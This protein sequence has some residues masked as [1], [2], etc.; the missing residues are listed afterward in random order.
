[1]HYARVMPVYQKHSGLA[2]AAAWLAVFALTA[3]YVFA[4][5]HGVVSIDI[6]RD[7]YWGQRIALGEAWPL[8]GPPV[9]TTTLLGPVWYYGVAAA[10]SV[11]GSFTAYFAL[12]G[13]LAASKFALAFVVGRRW[14]GPAFGVS[15][16]VASAAPGIA[17]YQLLGMGHPWFVET[18]LWLAA[19]CALNLRAAPQRQD[20]AFGLGATVALALHA[21]PTAIVL[22]PWAWVVLHRLPATQR[23]RAWVASVVGAAIVFAPVVLAVLFPVLTESSAADHAT[24]ASGVGGF[25]GLVGLGGSLAALTGAAAIAQNL[26]WAQ[27]MHVFNTFLQSTLLPASI[28]FALWVGV[29]AASLIGGCRA[30]QEPRLRGTLIGSLLSL[31]WAIITVSM[32]RNHTPFYMAFVLLLPFA[33]LLA[34]AW[35]GLLGR[36]ST[37]ERGLWL[38][39]LFITASLHATASLGLANAAH[40]GAVN[41]YLPLHSNMQDVTTA[42]HLESV[43]AAPTRDA[44]ARWL[45]SQPQPVSLHGDLAAAFDVGLHLDTELACS[46]QRRSD[47]TGG[48]ARPF[49]GLPS[50]AWQRLD[51]RSGGSGRG[52]HEVGAYALW[53][54]KQVYLP[55]QALAAGNGRRY[56]PRFEL[57]I[58]ALQRGAWDTSVVA[59]S[60]DVVVVSSLLPTLPNFSVAAIAN[61][62]PQIAMVSFAN[63]AV[64][65]CG[66]CAV[67]S[68]DWRLSISGGLPEAVSITTVTTAD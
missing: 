12:M 23:L 61:G 27:A 18:T 34:V 38:T 21:H 53:P 49:V 32:L 55:A 45:C 26:L 41:S 57:M 7:V 28:A 19:W 29:L 63:T 11:S 25:T 31:L 14:L 51:V 33:V 10:L 16:A 48:H 3:A 6:A 50:W 9:G 54:A 36:G 44:L 40:Y 4:I 30:W 1:M 35:V 22:V 59:P 5:A 56:P 17:S 2:V 24:G 47:T 58:K 8:L 13:L 43:V 42:A 64:F 66:T 60:Q 67:G 46:Q 39:T 52:E 37:G 62:A 65:R 20:F 68:V 15:L